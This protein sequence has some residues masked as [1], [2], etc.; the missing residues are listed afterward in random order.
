M[1]RA[2]AR[3]RPP[4]PQDLPP[5]LAPTVATVAPRF[6][7]RVHVSRFEPNEF[8]PGGSGDA[9]F[10]PL[11]RPDGIPIPTL[12]LASTLEAALLE[13]VLHDVPTPPDN[14]TLDLERLREQQFV[15][16]RLRPKRALQ[17]N[18]LSAKGL[19][20]ISLTRTDLIDTPVSEYP[21]TR[22]WADW[23]HSQKRT[24]GLTW[25]SRQDDQAR[26]CMLFGDRLSRRA[27]TADIA[28]EPLWESPHLDTLLALA[29]RI[30]IRRAFS[31]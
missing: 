25:V 30:G 7:W 9:R 18:D 28:S 16:S 4:L 31:T 26:A 5:T 3:K 24:H 23:L 6:W 8:H 12:Y 13:T 11:T 15:A 22:A 14:Y 10:S 29:D 1:A 2:A 19:K 17:L 27:L 20:R 21:Y